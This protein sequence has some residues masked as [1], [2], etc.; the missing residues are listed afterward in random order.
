MNPIPIDPRKAKSPAALTTGLIKS[1]VKTDRLNESKT[2]RA[3][4]SQHA[5]LKRQCEEAGV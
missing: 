3:G 1:A 4:Q 2:N 5:E